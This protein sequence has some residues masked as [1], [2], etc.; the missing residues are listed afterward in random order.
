MGFNI[1]VKGCLRP[2]SSASVRGTGTFP[3]FFFLKG[4]YPAVLY[5]LFTPMMFVLNFLL[6]LLFERGSFIRVTDVRPKLNKTNLMN[7]MCIVSGSC[8]V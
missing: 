5:A 3:V 2:F 4:S 8:V 6:L 7:G 1:E